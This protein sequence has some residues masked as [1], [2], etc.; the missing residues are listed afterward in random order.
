MPRPSQRNPGQNRRER[1]RRDGSRVPNP[2]ANF[3]NSLGVNR[4]VSFA[5]S[6]LRANNDL[7]ASILNLTNTNS[8]RSNQ[9]RGRNR[10]RSPSR[11]QRFRE[12]N[13]RERDDRD[14]RD[15]SRDHRRSERSDRTDRDGDVEFTGLEDNTSAPKPQAQVVAIAAPAAVAV[16]DAAPAAPG[17]LPDPAPLQAPAAAPRGPSLTLA[18]YTARRRA[19][20]REAARRTDPV[21]IAAAAL[22]EAAE[23]AAQVASEEDHNDNNAEDVNDNDAPALSQN[24]ETPTHPEDVLEVDYEE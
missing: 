7:A 5:E 20:L 9:N 23:E 24:Q 8:Q 12:R 16:S 14:Y 13:Y 18:E 4:A 21:E 2:R 1:E 6:V 10:S 15:R 11:R 17:Q 3:P 22:R 19:A